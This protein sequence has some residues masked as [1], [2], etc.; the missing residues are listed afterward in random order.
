M[1]TT[2]GLILIDVRSR[3]GESKIPALLAHEGQHLADKNSDSPFGREH[4][5]FDVQYGF[6]RTLGL[7]DRRKSDADIHK[8]YGY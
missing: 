2:R 6:G 4:R 1:Q 5:A 3:I 7:S 8:E